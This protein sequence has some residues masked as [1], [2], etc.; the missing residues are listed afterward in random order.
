MKKVYLGIVM[1]VFIVMASGLVSSMTITISEQDSFNPTLSSNSTVETNFSHIRPYDENCMEEQKGSNLV[2]RLGNESGGYLRLN[3]IEDNVEISD[4]ASLKPTA[5]MSISFWF[6][7]KQNNTNKG[8][9]DKRGGGGANGF[10]IQGSNAE[11]SELECWFYMDAAWKGTRGIQTK[12]P[13][14]GEWH[15]YMCQYNGTSINAYVDGVLDAIFSHSSVITHSTDAIRIGESISGLESMDG[16]IDKVE[17][18]NKSLSPTDIL[19]L[20]N[21]GRESKVQRNTTF[22]VSQYL[23]DDILSPTATDS[24]GS[25][26]G[27]FNNG[28]TYFTDDTLNSVPY[29]YDDD[30]SV[31]SFD[32]DDDYV[33]AG[34]DSS[35][36]VDTITISTWA[37]TDSERAIQFIAGYGNTAQEGYWVGISASKFVFSA[38][39]G[40]HGNQLGSGITPVVGQWKHVLGTYNGSRISIYIDGTLKA[41]DDTSASG[42]LGDYAILNDGFL[43]GNTETFV[44]S[45]FFNGSI[46]KVEIWNESLSATD[47]ENLFLDGRKSTTQR[48]ASFLVSQYLFDDSSSATAIDSKGSND[49]TFEDDANYSLDVIGMMAYYPFDENESIV[50]D[51]CSNDNDGTVTSPA[52]FNATSLFY[53]GFE[54]NG[55]DGLIDTGS[56]IIGVKDASVCAWIYPRGWGENG[57]GR[58]V[59][60]FGFSYFISDNGNTTRFSNNAPN[61]IVDAATNAIVLNTWSHTCVTRNSSGHANMYIDGSLSGTP[62]Q[63]ASVPTAD[64]DNLIIGNRVGGSRTWNGTIDEVM[65]FEGVLTAK[66]IEDIYLNQSK[67][68]YQPSLQEI[69]QFDVNMTSGFNTINLSLEGYQRNQDT[70]L[71]ARLGEWDVSQGYKEYDFTS[72]T[73]GSFDG[74]GDYVE[75]GYSITE[76]DTLAMSMWVYLNELTSD[77]GDR[78]DLSNNLYIH[79]AND[80]VYVT[81]T[82]HYFAVPI[83]ANVWHHLLLNYSGDVETSSLWIDGVREGPGYGVGTRAM[84]LISNLRLSSSS[85]TRSLNGSIDEVRIYERIVTS[86]EVAEINASGR[87]ANNSINDTGLVAYYD[88]NEDGYEGDGQLVLDKSGNDNHGT[89]EDNFKWDSDIPDG[90]VSYYHF[91]ES[92]LDAMGLNDGV[93]TSVLNNSVGRFSGAYE[94]NGDSGEVDTGSDFIDVGDDS[95]CAWIYPRSFGENNLGRIMDNSKFIFF[96][97]SDGDELRFS[98][99]NIATSAS[100]DNSITLNIWQHVCVARNSTGNINFYI[101]G[102]INGNE[103]QDSGT[104]TSGTTNI[105]IG[106]NDAQDRTFNGFIDE[107]MIFNRSLSSSEVKQ[108]YVKGRPQWDYTNYQN[109][110]A[111]DANDNASS[112]GFTISTATTNILTTI[113]FITNPFSFYSPILKAVAGFSYDIKDYTNPLIE[114]ISPTEV[115]NKVKNQDFVAVTTSMEENDTSN[116]TYTLFNQSIPSFSSLSAYYTFDRIGGNSDAYDYSGN[117][118]NGTLTSVVLNES[119]RFGRGYEFNGDDSLIDTGSDFIGDG[120]DS[121]CAWIYPIGGDL[122]VSQRIIANGKIFF[123]FQKGADKMDFSS[124]NGVTE[125]F[126]S[127]G[128]ITLNTWQH[129]C[130]TRNSTGN[131]NLYVNGVL[132]G[133]ANQDSGTPESGTTNLFIG[134]NS[135]GTR[136]F[137]GTI[138]D[139]LIFSKELTATEISEIYNRTQVERTTYQSK[140]ET[141]TFS[142]L[143][144]NEDYTYWTDIFD[145]SLNYN[146][147][148]VRRITLDST[149]PLIEFASSTPVNNTYTQNTTYTTNTTIIEKNLGSLIYNHNGTNFTIFNDSVVAMYN[150]DN[151]ASIGDSDELVKD[152]SGNGND[153]EVT[154]ATFT[155]D[156]R[157]NSAYEF[158]GISSIIELGKPSSL[159]F[160]NNRNIAIFA[161]VNPESLISSQGVVAQDNPNNYVFQLGASTSPSIWRARLF[162][163][164]GVAGNGTSYNFNVIELNEWHY[165]GFTYDGSNVRTYYDGVLQHTTARNLDFTTTQYDTHIGLYDI[166]NFNGT[167]DEVIILNRSLSTEEVQQLYFTNLNKYDTDKWQLLV[168]QSLNTTTGLPDGEYTYQTFVEDKV[169]LSNQTEQRLITIDTTTPTVTLILPEHGTM[170]TDGVVRFEFNVT[171]TNSID[172]CSLTYQ[173][174]IYTTS[175]SVTKGV[176]NV[177]EVVGINNLHP[178]YSDDLQWGINCTDNVGN[179]GNSTIFALDTKEFIGSGGIGGG[180]GISVDQNPKYL[181]IF[182]EKDWKKGE[183]HTIRVQVFDNNNDMYNRSDVS[184]KLPFGISLEHLEINEEYEATFF[185]S[186]S[187]E[188]GIEKITVVVDDDI[189]KEKEITITITEGEEFE[190]QFSKLLG[191][192]SEIGTNAF[193]FMIAGIILLVIVLI[194]MFFAMMQRKK[195]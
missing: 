2:R 81:G 195:E 177:I 183:F 77:S 160:T 45:R 54:F 42:D 27:T 190:A 144:D 1:L 8:F 102:A 4:D 82:S 66:Q 189:V 92:P 91:D 193:F 29:C 49:G 56:S 106:N 115:D 188:L 137:N 69:L 141:H 157:Y 20:Y 26:T 174:G 118:N 79:N 74:D 11:G 163:G 55:V 158:D 121:V 70:N 67:R 7:A 147:T 50:Y 114:F 39:N 185:V 58:I 51:Y 179:V 41:F 22:L 105:I 19:N 125:A 62:N 28:A 108:L 86:G 155:S 65:I 12:S 130:G 90:L 10:S 109:L 119:G 64:P 100:S 165:I 95:V 96:I 181:N 107:L 116:V 146:S 175:T 138:D 152:I 73:Y 93:V 159:D 173:G 112:N 87:I 59:E 46:D 182:Y 136:G 168:N 129:V 9:I 52:L 97:S 170:D 47:V 134:S 128:S 80:Y 48:N 88:F 43:I 180:G 78:V 123:L 99:D 33:D 98:S 171:D 151:V 3:G 83:T 148:E 32:G 186:D 34:D 16:S 21:D 36:E 131:A 94:F 75:T 14:Y 145:S 178:L 76:N 57:G 63:F 15:H 113:N 13:S 31:A 172:N 84:P 38:G 40:T 164:N 104:P 111:T 166:A 133:D 139:L 101:D 187:V 153:G 117:G 89:Q 150:F 132:S 6:N 53:G 176:A 30:N 35:L 184:F 149:F 85:A 156:G 44:P 72:E 126:S 127:D 71:S 110:T 18:W 103:N 37:R 135:A 68:Y 161:W 17:I 169:G 122:V 191:D 23:F 124:T 167:I 162:T 5:E 61:D 24:F 143:P 140:Q 60:D 154:N 194:T 192:I 120:A 25:N 142:S